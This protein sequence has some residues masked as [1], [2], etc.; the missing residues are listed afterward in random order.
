[1]FMHVFYKTRKPAFVKVV[2]LSPNTMCY[3]FFIAYP[4]TAAFLTA[5]QFAVFCAYAPLTHGE[6]YLGFMIYSLLRQPK[7]FP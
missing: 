5:C 7:L 6:G 1:M 3:M 2:F 4:R